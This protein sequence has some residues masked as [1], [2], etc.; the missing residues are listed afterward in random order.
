MNAVSGLGGA[1]RFEA[2]TRNQEAIN[3]DIVR[4][5]SRAP[6]D[7][8]Q[9]FRTE[10]FDGVVRWSARYANFEQLTTLLFK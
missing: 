9:I 4:Q 5:I 3:A 8:R 7:L 6:S 2:G 1:S 10:G